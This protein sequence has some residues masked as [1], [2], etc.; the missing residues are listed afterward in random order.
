MTL[1][2]L[3]ADYINIGHNGSIE[4]R[5]ADRWLFQAERLFSQKL[6]PD[7]SGASIWVA[8]ANR[9]FLLQRMAAGLA[10]KSR[11]EALARRLNAFSNAGPFAFRYGPYL[12]GWQL[13]QIALE[14]AMEALRSCRCFHG[15]GLVISPEYGLSITSILD[16]GIASDYVVNYMAAPSILSAEANFLE[17][18]L[19]TCSL[20]VQAHEVTD[21]QKHRSD[22]RPLCDFV[23]FEGVRTLKHRMCAQ[24]MT[25]L[26][27][28]T[29][30]YLTAGGMLII[31]DLKLREDPV[32]AMLWRAGP[33]DGI[34]AFLRAFQ[35]AYSVL[36]EGKRSLILLKAA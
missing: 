19:Q 10:V 4:S 27:L 6:L 13:H 36:R 25:E 23:Y 24:D 16:L 12:T 31:E 22:K 29:W 33:E 1:G 18:N 7:V 35:G 8:H 9:Q 34:I 30:N 28:I 26:L 21:R 32:S 5:I 11:D 20:G 3:I 17:F 14:E 2:E 15:A